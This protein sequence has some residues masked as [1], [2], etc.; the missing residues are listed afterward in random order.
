MGIRKIG[1]QKKYMN[2]ITNKWLDAIEQTFKNYHGRIW[3]VL[4]D[5]FPMQQLEQTYRVCIDMIG[6]EKQSAR[7]MGMGFAG[8]AYRFRTMAENDDIFTASII[9][10]GCGPS[11]NDYYKQITSL[12]IFFVSGLSCIESFYFA[13]HSLGHYYRQECFK[14]SPKALKKVTCKNVAEDFKRFWN[15]S[16]LTLEMTKLVESDEFKEWS[17]IR[18]ILSHRL[19]LPREI[20]FD[21]QAGSTSAN[22]LRQ[23][24]GSKGSNNPLNEKAT[25][26]RR[27]WISKQISLLIDSFELF[28]QELSFNDK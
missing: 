26:N 17:E 5:D 2:E 27:G 9:Q 6:S 16:N 20:I 12:Y 1:S 7:L 11:S 18:N 21:C 22:L 25:S 3:G 13:I 19:V 28:I 4:P 15:G 8:V 14:L 24:A 23:Q 10:D